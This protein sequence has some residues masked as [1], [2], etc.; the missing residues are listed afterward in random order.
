[1]GTP[2]DHR[3]SASQ[4]KPPY[5][6]RALTAPS[7]QASR[8]S[9]TG[10]SL[11]EMLATLAV[12]GIVISCA[13]LVILTATRLHFELSSIL[14]GAVARQK[15]IAAV[16]AALR[17]LDRHRFDG[18]VVITSAEDALS[19]NH[20]VSNVSGTSA[21]R[22]HSDIVSV[23]EVSPLER[24]VLVSA[25]RGSTTISLTACSFFKRPVL[26]EVRSY[27]LVDLDGFQHVTAQLVASGADCLRG[28]AQPLR[29]IFTAPGYHTGS[30]HYILPV[31]REYSLF[32]DR[33]GQLRLVSHVGQRVIENQPI[34]R[35][36]SFLRVVRETHG[37]GAVLFRI[38][39]KP[40][41]A[42]AQTATHF[43]SLTRRS[44]LQEVLG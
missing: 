4:H 39:V 32:I 19:G 6:V 34:V 44:S 2:V 17:S 37:S 16:D 10:A 42:Q 28:T 43:V 24:G 33:S 35:G 13:S 11:I 12:S 21:P 25:D 7:I 3:L 26:S 38:T 31:L 23:V 40:T 14:N 30:L 36:L 9:Q 29:S 5:S 8:F 18:G 20:P 27:L 1:M 41:G 15:T 22:G